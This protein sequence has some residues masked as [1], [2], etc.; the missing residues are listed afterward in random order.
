MQTNPTHR[1]LIIGSD[2]AVAFWVQQSLKE[3]HIMVDRAVDGTTGTGLSTPS[4]YDIIL[5][6]LS[7]SEGNGLNS[8][9]ELRQYDIAVPVLCLS[10]KD[11]RQEIIKALNMG[12]DDAVSVSIARE[13]LA[14]RIKA[15]LRRTIPSAEPEWIVCGTVELN[16]KQRKVWKSGKRSHL[17][18][19]ECA[20]LKFLMQHPDEVFSKKDLTERVWLK[21]FGSSSKTIGAYIALLRQKLETDPSSPQL[22][23]TVSGKG[24]VF[25]GEAATV[26]ENPEKQADL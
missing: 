20:L 23:C 1:A 13:E 7:L 17:S 26:D 25:K 3:N 6:D 19:R 10:N 12:A 9:Q 5:L 24:Y 22:L 11:D 8:L 16:A 4:A 21:E 15:L 18:K 2:N 14:A